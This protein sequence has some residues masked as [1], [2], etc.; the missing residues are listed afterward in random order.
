MV[1]ERVAGVL[2]QLNERDQQSPWVGAV[3]DK[4]LQK[5][6]ISFGK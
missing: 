2:D 6:P 5:N 1:P 4:S 3:H